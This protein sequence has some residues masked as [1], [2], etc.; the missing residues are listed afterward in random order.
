MFVSHEGL[1][2]WCRQGYEVQAY[3]RFYF[4]ETAITNEYCIA[5]V[6]PDRHLAHWLSFGLSG[7]DD[8]KW[9]QVVPDIDDRSKW[10]LINISQQDGTYKIEC[11]YREKIQGYITCELEGYKWSLLTVDKNKAGLYSLYENSN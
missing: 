7:D 5:S 6:Y 9:I 8:E 2:G 4:Y 1:Y 10:R 3:S 11:Y